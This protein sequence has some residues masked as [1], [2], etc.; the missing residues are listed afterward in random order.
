MNFGSIYDSSDEG[1]SM[2]NVTCVHVA[3][4]VSP[5]EV[6]IRDQRGAVAEDKI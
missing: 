5:V 4:A 1:I 3:W 2:N 6:S